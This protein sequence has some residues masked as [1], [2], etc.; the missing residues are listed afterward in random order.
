MTGNGGIA[1]VIECLPSKHK[2]LNSNTST[3]KKKK[4]MTVEGGRMGGERRKDEL[5][6]VEMNRE[7]GNWRQTRMKNF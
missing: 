7:E 3:A 5:V 4:S 1:Q 6:P 2:D